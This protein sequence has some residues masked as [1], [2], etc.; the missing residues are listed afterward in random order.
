[1]QQASNDKAAYDESCNAK[2]YALPIGALLCGFAAIGFGMLWIYAL[3]PFLLAAFLLCGWYLWKLQ[4]KK[5]LR[6]ELLS[7]Y[8][9]LPPSSWIA[10]AEQYR[11]QAE[12]FRQQDSTS[13]ALLQLRREQLETVAQKILALTDGL[14]PED[15]AAKWQDILSLHSRLSQ[16]E[17][18]AR[19]AAVRAADLEA[20]IPAA[21]P[22]T[23]PDC[24]TLS[25]QE[26]EA[27]IALLTQQLQQLQLQAGK[28]MGQID[29]LGREELLQKQLQQLEE[30]IQKLED[31]YYAA[32]LALAHLEQATL[33]LQQRFAPQLTARARTIFASLTGGRYDRLQLD[34]QLQLKAAAEDEDSLQP[35]RWRS[36]GT[37]DQLY[38]ALR[39][40]VAEQLTPTAP[41]VLDDVLV[42]FDDL[43]HTAAMNLLAETAEHKQVLIFTCQSREA[44]YSPENIIEI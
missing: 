13:K 11:A 17:E 5:Q 44:A 7:R 37:I 19:Q 26:T 39:L 10:V 2:P 32:T 23:A 27:Q 6:N 4:Q 1:M 41:L 12:S 20:S 18:V 14:S 34:Q 43:R 35:A 21:V 40:A 28:C 24:L 9:T 36:D 8:G 3:I 42:R 29:A 22:P 33:Q 16:A 30:R 15:A 38:L 25:P 31:L